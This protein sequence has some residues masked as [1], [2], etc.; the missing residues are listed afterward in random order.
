MEQ[1]ATDADPAMPAS[2]G[3]STVV[4]GQHVD[5]AGKLVV[6]HVEDQLFL[7]LQAAGSLA[8]VRKPMFESII[9]RTY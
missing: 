9:H 8:M 2:S 5:A 4:I 3:P 1:D 7:G 6:A